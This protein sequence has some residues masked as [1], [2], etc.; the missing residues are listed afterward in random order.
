MHGSETG[1]CRIICSE[2]ADLHFL[3]HNRLSITE[4]NSQ[5]FTQTFTQVVHILLFINV[6]LMAIIVL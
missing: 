4:V 2:M 1:V 5:T 6:L 3:C